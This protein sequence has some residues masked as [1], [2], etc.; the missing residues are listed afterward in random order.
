MV[1]VIFTVLNEVGTLQTLLDSLAAQ[2]REPDEVVVCDGGSSDGTAALIHAETDRSRLKLRFLLEPGA[3]ISRGRNLA[4][5]AATGEIIACCDAGVRLEPDWLQQI[6]APFREN[7]VPVPGVF[8]PPPPPN[9]VAG[10]FVPEPRSIFEIALSATTLPVL[11]EIDTHT[12]LPSS[13]S[14]AFQKSA[15]QA[16]GGYPEW[17]DYC[18]DLLFDFA[19]RE[20]SGGFTFAPRAIVHFR[21]RSTLNAF[22]RQY[23]L[24]ARGDGKANLWMKR[25]LVRY[26]TYL[27]A[28]PAITIGLVLVSPLVLLLLAVGAGLYLRQPYHRL[29]Q[30]PGFAEL[31]V[32]RKIQ[33]AALIPLIRFV[34]DVAKMIGYP[35]GV[36]WR[37]RHYGKP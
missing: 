19:I 22:A 35:V 15:W 10:F 1:T 2:T 20:S 31:P 24:Y 6:T 29:P 17:L 26:A 23:Y 5:G 16:A 4:I 11:G 33:A 3:N 12:F 18:E 8:A 27:I 13:R 7:E 34:G 14:V 30:V 32:S 9:A 28:L 37:A 21:P 36:L 25:H